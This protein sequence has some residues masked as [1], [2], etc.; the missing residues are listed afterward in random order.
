MANNITTAAAPFGA[1]TIH[2]M[3]TAVSGV[4]E[5]LRAW[6]ET[7]RTI[8]A[9]RALSPAQLDD[10]GLTRSQVEDFGHKGR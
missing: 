7:R 5:N 3:V 4:A 8:N 2:R 1:I 10:I 9:L 6:N